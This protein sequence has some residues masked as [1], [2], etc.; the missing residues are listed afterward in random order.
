[1][2]CVG[3][4]KSAWNDCSRGFPGNRGKGRGEWI[5]SPLVFLLSLPPAAEPKLVPLVVLSRFSIELVLP[6]L[7]SSLDRPAISVPQWGRPTSLFLKT[8]TTTPPGSGSVLSPLFSSDVLTLTF[9]FP[10]RLCP[11]TNTVGSPS[12]LP[13]LPG[14]PPLSI[15]KAS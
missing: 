11:I 6:P 8:L 3:W 4:G 2:M 15:F 13:L 5:I 14:S 9:C 10:A 1:M 12:F 7:P